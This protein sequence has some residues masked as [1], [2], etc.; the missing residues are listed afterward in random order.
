MDDF[1]YI[2]YLQDIDPDLNHYTDY[3]V[4]FNS[5]DL[6][7]LRNNLNINNGFNILHHNTRSLLAEGRLDEYN[8]ILNMLNNPFH[9]LAFSETWLKS[10]NANNILIE[11]FEHVFI[12]RPPVGNNLRNVGGGLSLFIKQGLS[13]TI[14]NHLNIMEPYMESLFIEVNYNDNKKIIGLIYRIPN[15]NS[16][17]FINKLNQLLESIDNKHELILLGDFNIDLLKDNTHARDFHYMMLSNYLTPTILDA[18]RVSTVN[19]NSQSFSSE[20]LIDNIFISRKEDFVSGLLKTSITDHYPIFISLATNSDTIN[21]DPKTIKTR[22][23]DKN[24]INNFKLE[25]H[26]LLLN[27]IPSIDDAQ[28]AFSRYFH[29]FSSLYDK[30]F[31]VT[32]KLMKEK[33]ILKPWINELL[34][35]RI[36][37]RDRLAIL[38]YKDKIKKEV[39]TKFRNKL[40]GQL[41][42]AKYNYFNSE[43]LKF[44]SNGKKT[45]SIINNAIGKN[46][47]SMS[48]T[49]KDNNLDMNGESVSSLFSDYF[50]NIANQ[51]VPDTAPITTD[52]RSYLSNRNNKSFFMNPIIESEIETAISQLKNSSTLL[53]ISSAVLENIKS[54]ISPHLTNIY[55]LCINQ[56]YFPN[57]LKIGRITPVHKKGC[58]Y[59]VSNYR[60]ICSL[61]P[62]SRILEKI[63]NNRMLEFIEKYNIFSSS[64]YGFRK[65]MGTEAALTNFIKYIHNSLTK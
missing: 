11:G 63:V 62:F 52:F 16:K 10:D 58:K 41:R 57:E 61:S 21:S 49:L 65:G 24:R 44:Q 27:A 55:N 28:I 60:P 13:F 33:S 40:N 35:E 1:N 12:V 19:K 14:C 43:F 17:L 53:S 6:D 8:F 39:F 59:S 15:T 42:T 20:T 25:L 34:I 7:S 4:N 50:A 9:I 18:T 47:K 23:I 56:G 31:P 54:T 32:S 36:K 51:L 48:I 38:S 37:I 22:L 64:Q 46:N 2:H 5:Y 3:S 29:I 45:W 30:Y 26:K